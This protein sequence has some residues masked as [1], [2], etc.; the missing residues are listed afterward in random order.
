MLNVTIINVLIIYFN[1]YLSLQCVCDISHRGVSWRLFICLDFQ[2]HVSRNHKSAHFN[3]YRNTCSNGLPLVVWIGSL[4]STMDCCYYVFIDPVI[5]QYMG[6][7]SSR[8]SRYKE[9]M[10][11]T[12]PLNSPC[13]RFPTRVV[14]ELF[15]I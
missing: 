14:N 12:Y 15:L 7:F 5:F 9:G 6:L 10:V 2:E 3:F 4:N 8:K 11:L 13:G 1:F